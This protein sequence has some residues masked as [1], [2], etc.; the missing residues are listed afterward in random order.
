MASRKVLLIGSKGALGKDVAVAF[1]KR[2]WKALCV[3][4]SPAAA[5]LAP[6]GSVLLKSDMSLQQMQDSILASAKA[7]KFDAVINVAGGWAGGNVADP[8]A[9]ANAELMLRQSV[10][11]S[12]AAAHI[13]AVTANPNALL[14]LPGSA[15]ALGPTSFMLGYGFA[16]AAVHHLVKSVA[17][18]PSLTPPGFCV[19]GML[20]VTLDTP[21]NRAA[22]PQA[23]R[24][25]WTPTPFVAD[26]LVQW[27]EA[28]N[29]RPKS[30]TLVSF[31]TA[32]G[33]TTLKHD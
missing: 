1:S 6:L 26:T 18:D 20:P 3:D 13:A 12:M 15:A 17:A 31:H 29:T 22:M 30:G 4:L 11:S 2:S 7:H 27:A 32:G 25:T 14:L 24:S 10:F 8:H 28:P 33:K 21:G 23:D 16:K 5:E 9:A 19:L